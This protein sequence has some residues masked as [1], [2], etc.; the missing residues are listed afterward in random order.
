MENEGWA[1][2]MWCSKWHYFNDGQQS[3][4]GN[5]IAEV[6]QVLEVGNDNSPNNCSV[7]R[8]K[9]TRMRMEKNENVGH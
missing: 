4:C 8:E 1:R 2:P 6:E 9:L 5:V 7:C 3:L